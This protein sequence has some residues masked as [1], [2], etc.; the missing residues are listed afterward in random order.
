MHRQASSEVTRLTCG[1]RGRSIGPEQ[2]CRTWD[3]QGQA[4]QLVH[5]TAVVVL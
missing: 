3:G 1:T 4:A 2:Q 5:V